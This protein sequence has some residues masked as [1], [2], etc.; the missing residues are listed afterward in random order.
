LE[1]LVI[2]AGSVAA[3]QGVPKPDLS[4]ALT[5]RSLANLDFDEPDWSAIAFA[6]AEAE[7]CQL[8][9]FWRKALHSRFAPTIVRTAWTS[10]ALWVYAELTDFDIYNPALPLNN[11]P[12]LF[13]DTFEIFLQPGPCPGYFEMHVAPHN[14]HLQL[15]YPQGKFPIPR[16]ESIIHDPHFFRSRVLLDHENNRWCVLAEFPSMKLSR[17]E[18]SPGEQWRFS[19]SRYDY[20]QGYEHPVLSSTSPHPRTNFHDRVSYRALIFEG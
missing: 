13:G 15:Q 17:R 11:D 7:A 18:I 9:Q 8:A 12:Y 6:F 16:D 14:Q 1:A 3:S 4:A 19:F 10:D 20:T 5:C 2:E